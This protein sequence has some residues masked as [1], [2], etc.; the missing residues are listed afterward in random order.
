MAT[1]SLPRPGVKVIQEFRTTSPTLLVPAMPACV[2]GVAKQ[3]VESVDDTGA[4]SADARLSLPAMLRCLFT[5]TTYSALES[6]TLVLSVNG[7]P[8]VTI[9]FPATPVNPTPADAASY[10]NGLGITGLKAVVE[11]SGGQ[12]RLVLLTTNTGDFASLK[13]I[14]GTGL[15]TLGLRAGQ[16]DVGRDGYNNYYDAYIDLLSYPD[17]RDN[18]TD[19]T[20][21]YDTV[22]VFLDLGAGNY[23]EVLRT[24]SFLR[25]ATA[26]VTPF[27]DGDGDNLTPYLDFAGATFATSP[28]AA[29]VTGSAN[30]TTIDYTSAGPFNPPK[31][32]VVSIDGGPLQT[33]VL[34]E[35]GLAAAADVVTAINAVLGAGIASL[36]GNNL[37]LTSPTSTGGVESS[38]RIDASST[39]LATLGLTAAATFGTPYKPLVGDEVWVNGVRIGLITEVTSATRL[40]LDTEVSIPTFVGARYYIVAKGLDNSAASA[41]RP[42][43]DLLVDE[44]SGAVVIKQELVRDAA[45]V[46]TAAVGRGIYLGYTA[47]RKDVSPAAKEGFSILRLGGITNLEAALAPVDPSNPLA[48]G[49]YMAILNAPGLE[50]FGVGVDESSATEPF[51][52]VD[53]YARA[54]EYLESRDVYAIAPLTHD[55]NVATLADA[56]VTAMSDAEIGLERVAFFN[57]S[58]PTRQAN[59]L[60]ASGQL[61]NTAGA[62]G[63]VFDTGVAN[64]PALIAAAGLGPG[65]YTLSDGLFLTLEDD[66]RN[67]LILSVAGSVVTIDDGPLTGNTDGFYYDAANGNVFSTAVVDRPFTVA[68]RGKTLANLTEEAIAYGAI[69]QGYQ[70]RRLVFTTPDRA[71]AT[72]DGLEQ[73]VEG[74]YVAAALAGKTSSKAPQDPLTEVGIAGFTG[75]IGATDRYGEVQYRIMD[76]SGLWSMYQEATGQ[77]IKTRH[78]LSSDVSTVEKREFSITTAVDFTAKLVRGMLRNFIGRFNLTQQVKDAINT[79]FQGARA[80]LLEQGVLAD[81]DISTLRQDTTNPDILLVDC[82]VSVLY[83]LNQIR[84]TLVI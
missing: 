70:N 65:P 46:P 60:I 39:A 32:L 71:K 42:S 5:G 45:G 53:G 40:R 31:T 61:G 6:D 68:I 47:L 66:T 27:D 79:V 11:T 72:V 36:S 15:T 18:L 82:D 3:I 25:G 24:E 37:R 58:R 43:S 13:V 8:Q 20:I 57:P 49:M 77:L 41:T 52:T 83:P 55:L 59:T 56:H 64:L 84:V 10:I 12:S 29:V 16:V 4:L 7:A 23:R 80:F 50:V 44:A 73:I 62:P 54:F 76:G 21:D 14:S 69:P 81:F 22:R 17:P 19:L 48:F 35:T 51:G 38:I 63:D 74:F 2:M 1:P 9:T 33:V 78:Q 26:A 30:L 75:L 28:A 67:Y 34:D